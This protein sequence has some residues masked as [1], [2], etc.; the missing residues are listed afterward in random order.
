MV[1]R[2]LNMLFNQVSLKWSCIYGGDLFC[3]QMAPNKLDHNILGVETS[4]NVC[5]GLDLNC[6]LNRET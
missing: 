1:E 4:K 3:I 5:K 2:D 6:T